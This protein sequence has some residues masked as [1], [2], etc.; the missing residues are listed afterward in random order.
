MELDDD[1]LQPVAG[2]ENESEGEDDL[3]PLEEPNDPEPLDE[4][5]VVEAAET[6]IDSPEP[7]V[8][9]AALPSAR[10]DQVELQ[11][12]SGA[13]AVVPESPENESPAPSAAYFGPP[14]SLSISAARTLRIE[15]LRNLSCT[16][17][18][19]NDV[20]IVLNKLHMCSQFWCL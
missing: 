11:D 2:D 7:P 9:I 15:L 13:V 3:E 12:T 8:P 1:I 6:Q 14:E 4:T 10:H 5:Q 17:G 19:K 16:K 18:K 20:P